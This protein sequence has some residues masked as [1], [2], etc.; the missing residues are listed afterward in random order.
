[1]FG[2]KL[3]CD[4]HPIDIM[5]YTGNHCDNLKPINHNLYLG[6]ECMGVTY[7]LS[8]GDSNWILISRPIH[9]GPFN[10]T[11]KR[12][13]PNILALVDSRTDVVFEEL[14]DIVAYSIIPTSRLNVQAS[15]SPAVKAKS[16]RVT[17][18]NPNRSFCERL[19][20]YS[21]FGDVNGNFKNVII[22]LGNHVVSATS[23]ARDFCTGP[24]GLNM[25][26]SF[27]VYGCRFVFE[28][29]T[30]DFYTSVE[31]DGKVLPPLPCRLNI[32]AYV[33]CGFEIHLVRL[34]LRNN[35]TNRLITARNER[36]FPY[37]L[38]NGLGGHL[39]IGTYNLAVTIDGIKHPKVSFRVDDS[40]F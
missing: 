14:Q 33:Y 18:D 21:V 9:R 20:P 31:T 17:F 26:K 37:D 16:V 6:G 19:S 1:M 32:Q 25:T 28:F 3:V 36:V 11:I 13:L 10:V 7:F 24:A 15:F 5:A 27:T 34:E 4:N 30:K 22:P 12:T 39:A 8:S 38:Y 23:F 40:C 29:Y 35:I 2:T